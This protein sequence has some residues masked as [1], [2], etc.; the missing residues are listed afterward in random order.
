[1]NAKIVRAGMD[2]Q[3]RRVIHSGPTVIWPIGLALD[4]LDE[5]L[6]WVDGKVRR[7]NNYIYD[8]FNFSILMAQSTHLT[9]PAAT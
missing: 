9:T 5:R 7:S 1:M 6:F 4:L 8:E 2:G 3:S